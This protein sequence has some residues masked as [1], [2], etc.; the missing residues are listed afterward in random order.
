[1][2]SANKVFHY[3]AAVMMGGA[4]IGAGHGVV[5]ECNQYRHDV[6]VE[7]RNINDLWIR[8]W[9]TAFHHGLTGMLLTPV[10]PV[11]L[12]HKL[13]SSASSPCPSVQA[14]KKTLKSLLK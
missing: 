6:P 2:S 13:L 14:A 3:L 9:P 10:A 5:L 8:I 11:L 12:T 7:F 1:M 4:V